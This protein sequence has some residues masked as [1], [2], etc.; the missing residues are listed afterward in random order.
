MV[1]VLPE[2]RNS[3]AATV[4]TQLLNGFP[5]IRF[6][7]LVGIG[8]EVPGDEGEDDVQQGDVMVSQ[9]TATFG[10]VVQ[11]DLGKKRADGGFEMTGQ[12][13]KP[14]S[15][16]SA[17]VRKLQAQHSQVGSQIS[18]YLSEMTRRYRRMQSQYSF[19]AADYN[20]LI[21][22]SYAYRPGVTCDQCDQPQTI[23]R[24]ARSDAAAKGQCSS[25]SAVI[26][27]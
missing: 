27:L 17:D 19:P 20:Q 3:A 26:A 10:D 15:V 2:I 11:H 24:P 8:G 16:L 4:A 18:E 5:S 21:L 1:A 23:S 9:P 22:A 13:N 25:Y 12:L 7:L 14:P 6:G